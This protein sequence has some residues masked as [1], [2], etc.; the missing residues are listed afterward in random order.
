[1]LHLLSQKQPCLLIEGNKE[2]RGQAI[3]LAYSRSAQAGGQGIFQARL[4][5]G[6]GIFQSGWRGGEAFFQ[7]KI[8]HIRENEYNAIHLLKLNVYPPPKTK[9]NNVCKLLLYFC[10]L[11]SSKSSKIPDSRYH[12]STNADQ[13]WLTS[14]KGG[15]EAFFQVRS[16]GGRRNFKGQQ[17]GGRRIFQAV[18]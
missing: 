7:G 6:R 14:V 17:R 4:R 15:G 10:N 9:K 12:P 11:F 13:C 2:I 1:M 18:N 3:E 5:G 8:Q 16:G